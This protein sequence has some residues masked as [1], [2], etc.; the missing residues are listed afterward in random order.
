MTM[1]KTMLF[2]AVCALVISLLTGCASI[3]GYA[4]A[5]PATIRCKGKGAITG[6]G[7]APVAGGGFSIQADCGDGF[8]YQQTGDPK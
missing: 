2:L 6:Q 3:A 5:H 7:S 1:M 8:E 4:G